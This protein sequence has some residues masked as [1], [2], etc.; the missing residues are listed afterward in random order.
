LESAA[1]ANTTRGAAWALRTLAQAAAMTPDG[2]PLRADLAASIDANID[3]Y[4]SKYVARPANPLGLVRPYSNYNVGASPLTSA[5]W[6]DDFFTGAFGYLKD[7]RVH[8]ASR[9]AK[10][11]AFLAWKYRSVVGRLGSGGAGSYP[12]THAAQ[13]TLPYAPTDAADWTSGSGPW[14]ADWGEVARAMGL[15]TA[16]NAGDPLVT[17]YPTLPTGYW[18]N[19]LPALAYAVDHGAPGAPEAW[20]RLVSASNAGVQAEGYRDQPVWGVVPRPQPRERAGASG[21][22][23]LRR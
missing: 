19:L 1:G 6:M 5:V 21:W 3:Y 8:D 2:D 23:T 14:Y 17:G 16:T 4:H 15:P 10:L 20:N 18:S 13:Y 9:S 12:Y 11:D 22:R 7:L